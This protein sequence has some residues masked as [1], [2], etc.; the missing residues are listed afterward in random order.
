[1]IFLEIRAKKSILF[2]MNIGDNK[3]IYVLKNLF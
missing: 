3:N 2:S 1:M